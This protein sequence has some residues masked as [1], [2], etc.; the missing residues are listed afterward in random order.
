MMIIYFSFFFFFTFILYS[1]LVLYYTLNEQNPLK[2][3][4]KCNQSSSKCVIGNTIFTILGTLKRSYI[5]SKKEL[6]H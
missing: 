1:A 6:A 4:F 3:V 2:I 5:S